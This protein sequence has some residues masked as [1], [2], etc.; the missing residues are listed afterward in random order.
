MKSVQK[1]FLASLPLATLALTI[2]LSFKIYLASLISK[3]TLALFFTT[4]DFFALSLLILVGFRSSMIVTYARTKDDLKILN[5]FRIFLVVAILLAWGLIVPY[6]KHQMGVNVDYWYLVATLL[7]TALWTYLGNELSMYRMYGFMNYATFFEPIFTVIWFSI[8]WFGYGIHG[9]QSLFIGTIMGSLSLSVFLLYGKYKNRVKEPPIKL[10][11][12]DDKMKLFLKNSIISTVEFGSGIVMIYIAVILLLDYHTPEDLGNFQVVVKP[13]LVGLIAIFVFPIFKFFLPEFSK[14]AADNNYEEIKKLKDWQI[15]FIGFMSL[16][17]I[18]LFLA[19]GKD[20]LAF[21][22]PIEYGN[23]YLMLMHLI[24][25]FP[26]IALNALQLSILK[27]FG[28]FTEALLVRLSGVIVFVIA[29]YMIRFFSTSVI[30]V[31][32]GLNIGY[33]F[34][35]VISHFLQRKTLRTF[36]S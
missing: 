6:L 4:L 24:F 30:D 2:N 9:L 11:L 13:I 26:F 17:V 18:T 27:A 8:A 28:K 25:F 36:S 7:A 15:N 32:M 10:F 29:F 16:G 3:E 34:M 35:F 5:I 23:A 1:A 19:V 22:F 20:F 21:A 31:I 12:P 33:F 14:L